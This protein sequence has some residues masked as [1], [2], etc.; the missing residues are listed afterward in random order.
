MPRVG[1]RLLILGLLA[2]SVTVVAQQAQRTG[3]PGTRSTAWP[4]ARTTA[5][6]SVAGSGSDGGPPRRLHRCC[7]GS[8]ARPEVLRH[9]PQRSRQD[10][11]AVA[12]GHRARPTSPR[13][14]G[15]GEGRPQAARRDDAAAGHAAA[16]RGDARRVRVVARDV[17]RSQ[18]RSRSP[19]PGRSAAAP[20]EP[21]RVRQRRP[22]PARARHRRAD[23]AARRR[24]EQR[25]RQHRGR[26]ARVAVA[27]RAVSDGRAQDQQPGGRRPDTDAGRRGLPRAAGSTRRRITSKGCRSAR[28][29]AL[30][31]RHNFPLDAEYEFS[32]VLLQ[33]HRRLHDRARVG[34]TQLEISI[35]GERVFIGAGRRREGQ[36]AV[37]HEH[38]ATTARRRSTSACK[39]RVPVKA[40]PHDVGVTFLRSNSAESDEPLQPFTRNHDLQD[41]NGAAAHRL[42]QPD[43]TVQRDRPRR[44][45]EPAADLLVP[46][47]QA[48]ADEAACARTILS[49][50]A[51]RA[52]RRPVTDADID[53][54]ARLLRRGPQAQARF[55][56]GIETALR[57]ILASPKFLFRAEPDPPRG[58]RRD[59]IARV[60]TSSWRRGCRSS[61]G[62]AF[63]TTSC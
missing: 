1:L 10:R 23:A 46:P 34:R 5:A 19:N 38:V 8:G 17:A 6:Q 16:R 51:R 43:G 21:H 48:S 35:D 13:S 63:P 31:V 55:D 12:R 58:R 40:G 61:S 39:T 26:A 41:M 59:R 49:T 4:A 30:L 33:Q 14:R 25:V 50:L 27:A 15:L 9:L 24:R 45:A 62:A 11:R 60:A 42:R 44:H 22:R 20:P 28:A 3:T 37:G 2:T 54:T 18:A 47:G 57:F 52:Y 36:Q 29:A 53:A 56:A 7:S 32:V